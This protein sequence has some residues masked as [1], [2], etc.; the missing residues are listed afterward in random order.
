MIEES[1]VVS[2]SNI[3]FDLIS[4]DLLESFF[5]LPCRITTTDFVI[6]EIKTQR[7]L[8]AVQ[9]FIASGQLHV[10]SFEFSE[11]AN[12][13]ELYLN[14]GTNASITDCSVWY[15]AKKTEGRLLTGDAKLRRAA[16]ND[17]VKVSGLIY[18]LDN[19]IEYEIVDDALCAEKLKSL[20]AINHRL[21]ED[22][23]TKRINAWLKESIDIT[24]EL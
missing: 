2:D 21:P 19:L 12:I 9:S 23:C 4:V 5:L 13:N 1:I 15:Y 20:M 10:K 22:E 18:V 3:F 11:L 14:N 8:N 17:S 6:N 16:I 7:E 24:D